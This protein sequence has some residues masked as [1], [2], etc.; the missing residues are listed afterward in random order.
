M[1]RNIN[2]EFVGLW[3]HRPAYQDE[4]WNGFVWTEGVTRVAIKR[5]TEPFGS[6]SSWQLH[7]SYE[8]Q[9]VFCADRRKYLIV[10]PFTL[11]N[12]GEGDTPE[13]ALKNMYMRQRVKG[14]V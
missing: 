1:T 3:P 13:A 5:K 12:I 8:Y 7:S 14:E 9:L 6:G 10:K 11:K 2:P 4:M